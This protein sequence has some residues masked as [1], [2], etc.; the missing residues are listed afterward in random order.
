MNDRTLITLRDI[1]LAYGRR[2][3]LTGFSA[4]VEP[5]D[6]IVVTGANGSG[7]TTLLRR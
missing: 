3:V 6:F 4:I 2:Q 1:S 7:K 5:D